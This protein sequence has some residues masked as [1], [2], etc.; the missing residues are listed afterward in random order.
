MSTRF[1]RVVLLAQLV[2]SLLAAPTIAQEATPTGVEVGGIT[3][4]APDASYAEVSRG[5]WDARAW[6]WTASMPPEVNPNFDPTGERCGYGQSGPVFFLPEN[7]TGSPGTMTCIVPEGTA[8]FVPLG[9]TSCSTVD[10]PPYFGRNEEE[11]LACA[12]SFADDYS[13]L[14]VSI[15]SKQVPNLEDYRSSTP[16]FPIYF[17]EDHFYGLP[18]GAASAVA[19]GYSF[20]IAPPP[21]G[22]YEVT[23]SYVY[24]PEDVAITATYRVIVEAP[25]VIEPEATPAAGTPVATPAP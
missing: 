13:D 18:E 10:P 8:I 15:N 16:L 25:Q 5:E 12:V 6:Q 20:I 21:P 2:T 9:S 7:F 22:E 23:R 3:V 17:S 11:L 1:V 14:Q 19:E 4:L 24:A